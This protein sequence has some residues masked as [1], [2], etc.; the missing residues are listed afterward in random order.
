M[1]MKDLR[2]FM[3][4]PLADF[5]TLCEQKVKAKSKAEL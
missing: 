4:S 2:G 3:L 5:D 1:I